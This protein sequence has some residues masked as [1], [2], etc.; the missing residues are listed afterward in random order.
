MQV[1]ER[2]RD[3]DADTLINAQ[4]V[5]GVG[6]GVDPE[7]YP[8][9]DGL[10]DRIGAVTCATRKVTDEGWMPRARQVGITGHTI[11][12]HLYIAV[13]TSG[14]FNHMI[15]V[16]SAGTIVGINPDPKCELW[17]WCD[18]GVIAEWHDVL[19]SL[20]ERLSAIG[21]NA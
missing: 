5:I 13:G 8:V 3:D 1:E 21:V 14:K 11:A 18:V 6:R 9:I 2:W 15:G 12:P 16:R 10:A 17:D 19:E 4:V 20:V 7:D